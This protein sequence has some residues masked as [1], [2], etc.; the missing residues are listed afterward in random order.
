MFFL[1]AVPIKTR[2]I[3][4]WSW[5]LGMNGILRRPLILI[6]PHCSTPKN[7]RASEHVCERTSRGGGRWVLGPLPIFHPA[8]ALS[9][10]SQLLQHVPVV[11]HSV[12]RRCSGISSAVH[13]RLNQS[14]GSLILLRVF[15]EIVAV[16]SLILLR[17]FVEIVAVAFI[18]RSVRF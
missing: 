1:S 3:W 15:V 6:L 2:I 4:S 5:I 12:G 8:Q 14:R 18:P 11:H 16:G 13:Y 10:S 9:A 17:V 7:E